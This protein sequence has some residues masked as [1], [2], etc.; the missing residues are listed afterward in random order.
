MD[1]LAQYEKKVFLQGDADAIK[2]YVFE[3]S[4][5]PQIR[6]GSQRLVECEE[7][8][9]EYVKQ[10]G[11]EKIYCSG[12]GF[13]FEVPA[14]R[15]EEI[16]CSIE[17]IYLQHT[18]VATV[19]VVYED[20]SEAPPPAPDIA[21]GWAGRL[22]KAHR[23][24]QQAGEFARRT[25][26]LAA[27]LRQAKVQKT[28]APFIEAFPFGKRCDL[29]GKRVAEE[30]V[31]Y[32]EAGV[33]ETKY[34]CRVCFQRHETG[35][36]ERDWGFREF[37][38]K[39]GWTVKAEPARDLNIL[40]ESARRSYLAFLY[41]DGNNIGGLLQRV[42]KGQE[43]EALSY[44]L[45]EGT[46]RALFEALWEVCGHALQ[47][48]RVWPFEI[49]NIGGDDVTLLIQA[50]YAWE[51]AIAFLERFERYVQEEVESRLGRPWPERITASVGIA[52]ADAKHPVRY[53][54]ALA[55]DLL[56]RAKKVAKEC[57]GELNNAEKNT[58]KK[59]CSAIDF[60]WL[61]NAIAVT[62]AEMVANLY[63][64]GD[65]NLT[66]R[67]Y[68][69]TQA[70]EMQVVVDVLSEWPRSLRHRWGEALDRGKWASLGLV[71]YDLARRKGRK[72]QE[73]K[74]QTLLGA[75]ETLAK[76]FRKERE[77]PMGYLWWEDRENGK[78]TWRTALL[79]VLELAELR[80]MRPDIQEEGE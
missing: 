47:H 62:K 42:K 54:E 19:T 74:V 13:L 38:Q 75:L 61:P 40:V 66:A 46:K 52:V 22:V 77:V 10:Q 80:A 9:Q 29:C 28:T 15:A 32:T 48:E 63:R 43:Y 53:L 57:P 59:P 71:L 50:G 64:Q 36:N 41:A 20:T 27:R 17:N 76:T 70:K 65:L 18:Q 58:V 2:S 11:G 68:T 12:G 55:S 23:D 30:K 6:G 25:A 16:K 39:H 78:L 14:D 72:E 51:V 49:L 37:A 73:P 79:D 45:R 5:L 69:L 4:G 3:S 67:P 1:S 31:T 33:S 56:K 21:N 35:R 8:I 34:L 60:L 44:G 7:K 24:A 26:F